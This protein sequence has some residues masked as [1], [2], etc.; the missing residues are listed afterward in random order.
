MSKRFREL[1]DTVAP[2]V[3]FCNVVIRAMVSSLATKRSTVQ[4]FRVRG[5]RRVVNLAMTGGGGIGLEDG[6][7]DNRAFL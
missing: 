7:P 5:R 6:V 1:A 2:T 4:H 3:D